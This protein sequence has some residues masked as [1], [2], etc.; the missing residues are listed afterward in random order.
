MSRFYGAIPNTVDTRD[1]PIGALLQKCAVAFG[2]LPDAVDNSA[3]LGDVRDQSITQSC[4]PTAATKGI[5]GF[6]KARDIACPELA[7]LPSYAFTRGVNLLPGES[8]VDDGSMPRSFYSSAALFGVVP[9]SSFPFDPA[10][11]NDRV[12]LDVFE[13]GI[14]AR[15]KSYHTVLE[16]GQARVAA[17]RQALAGKLFPTLSMPVDIAFEE[18]AGISVYPGTTGPVLGMHALLLCGYRPGAFLLRNSWGI[19]WGA[20]GLGWVAESFIASDSCFDFM[21][22][23]ASP[24]SP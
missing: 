6:C 17:L 7:V 19:G 13:S 12:P 4:L 16:Q 1:L 15:V 10:R 22:A 3:F 18:L 2:E 5:F 24:G 23:N 11:V 8:L 21:A 20:G 14:A 9:E